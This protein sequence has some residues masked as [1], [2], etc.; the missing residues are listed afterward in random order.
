MKAADI[1]LVNNAGLVKG[2]DH[3]GEVCEWLPVDLQL[4]AAE[5]DVDVMFQTNGKLWRGAAGS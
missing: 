3:V 4:T 1:S 2:R 5:E